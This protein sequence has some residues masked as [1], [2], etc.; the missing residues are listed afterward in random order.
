MF[1]SISVPCRQREALSVNL[2]REVL[3]VFDYLIV[4]PHHHL[5]CKLETYNFVIQNLGTG[6]IYGV[7][8]GVIVLEKIL[9]TEELSLQYGGVGPVYLSVIAG[10]GDVAIWELNK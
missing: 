6:Q 4:G 3:E 1:N 10:V 5:H 2:P 8:P 9:Q 7:L